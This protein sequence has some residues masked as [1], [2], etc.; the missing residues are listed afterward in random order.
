MM[1]ASPSYKMLRKW[2]GFPC[3]IYFPSSNSN[4]DANLQLLTAVLLDEIGT[5]VHESCN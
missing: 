4:D 5:M 2:D 3:D 1:L